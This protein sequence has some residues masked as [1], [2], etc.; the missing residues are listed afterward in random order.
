M[1]I[2]PFYL[3]QPSNSNISNKP[4]S[5]QPWPSSKTCA[6]EDSAFPEPGNEVTQG[7]IADSGSP[8][9]QQDSVGTG[10]GTEIYEANAALG[11][12]TLNPDSVFDEDV[13]LNLRHRSK[14]GVLP[15]QF[16]V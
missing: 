1:K 11:G 10:T 12:S 5:A 8:V 14:R 4:E 9:I 15:R 2:N 13:N 3:M 6:D 7:P 16:I